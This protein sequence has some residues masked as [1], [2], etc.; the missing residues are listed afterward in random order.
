[1]ASGPNDENQK[2]IK[3][4][5]RDQRR[6]LDKKRSGIEIHREELSPLH[7][8]PAAPRREGMRDASRRRR[9]NAGGDRGRHVDSRTR[10]LFGGD[11]SSRKGAP[12]RLY[13]R[14]ARGGHFQSRR[15]RP[16]RAGAAL[17]SAYAKGRAATARPAHES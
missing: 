1:D 4:P 10:H 9:Q 12:D 17:S 14:E 3:K 6:T 8:G 13:R 15:T 7:V 11:D 16:L 5:G 2:A